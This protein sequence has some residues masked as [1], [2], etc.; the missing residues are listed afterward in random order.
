L[1]LR[2]VSA[3]Q[4][5]ADLNEFVFRFNRRFWPTAAFDA[6]LKIGMQN[7]GPTY[8]GIYQDTWAHPTSSA[9]PLET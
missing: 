1:L 8:A 3:K 4:L 6:G 7:T 9:P 2:T 5:Q